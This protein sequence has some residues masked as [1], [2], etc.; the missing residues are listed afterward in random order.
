M[1]NI[2]YS[3]MCE[4]E[5][6]VNKMKQAY[7]TREDSISL[8]Q[9]MKGTKHNLAQSAAAVWQTF[10]IENVIT[11]KEQTQMRE[12]GAPAKNKQ[13]KKKIMNQPHNSPSNSIFCSKL[14]LVT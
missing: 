7:I 8:N 13:K 9:W 2:L 4:D 5:F 3:L 14:I 11:Y 1:G 12:M 10:N 6:P